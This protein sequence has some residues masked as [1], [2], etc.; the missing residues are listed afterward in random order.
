M[1]L[2]SKS[3]FLY[4]FEVTDENSSLDFKASSGGSVLQATLTIGYYSLTSLMTEIVRAMEAVDPTNIYTV[5]A[6]RTVVG[7][8]QNRVTIATSGTFLSLLFSSGPRTASTCAELIGFNVADKTG[9]TTYTGDFSSGTVFI[10]DRIAYQFIPIDVHNEVIG[11]INISSIGVKETVVFSTQK[12]WQAQFKYIPKSEAENS[13]APLMLWMI[14]QRPI[15]FT[16]EI[17]T[18]S[19]FYSGT[20]EKTPASGTALA[21]KFTEMLPDFPDTY[22]SGVMTFRKDPLT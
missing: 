18:P 8:T 15:D 12:Y 21:F 9:A 16:P 13:W 20:L 4:G 19:T 14:Q 11:K 2:S 3:L 1:A 6:D 5:T 22:D 17:A 10:P 7:G